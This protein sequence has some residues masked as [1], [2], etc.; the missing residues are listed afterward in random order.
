MTAGLVYAD[1]RTIQPRDIARARMGAVLAG[2]NPSAFA[3]DAQQVTSQEMASWLPWLRS[4]DGEI[5]N[6]RDRV[7]ARARDLIR[8]D[9]YAAG[10]INR[11]L[12]AAV[13]AQFHP[14]PKP[15]WRALQ[16]YCPALDST[17]AM[18]VAAAVRS[19]YQLWADDPAKHCDAERTQTVQQMLRLSFRHKMVDGDGMIVALWA[20]DHVGSGGARYATQLQVVDPDRLSNPFQKMDT[21]SQR[22]GVEIDDLGAPLGYHIR[23]AHQNDWYDAGQSMVWD[24]F[25]RETPWGRPIVVHD[26]DRERASQHRGNGLLTA[27]LSRFKMLTKFDSVTLQAAVLRT[28]VGFFV[29]SPYDAEQ[30]RMAMEAGDDSE[31]QLAPSYYQGLREEWHR[32]NGVT[33]GGVRMPVMA[34]GESIETISG[35]EHA[36]DFD[37]FQGA[38]LRSFAASTGQSVEEISVDFRKV[39]YSSFRGAMLQSWRTLIRRRKDFA[40]NTATPIYGAWLEE[41]LSTHLSGL[42]PRNAPPF[43][44]IRAAYIACEWIGPG[45]GWVDPVKEPQGEVLKLDAAMGTLAET[46]ANISGRYWLDILDERQVEEAAMRDRGLQLPN[47]AGGEPANQVASK[48]SAVESEDIMDRL[49]ETV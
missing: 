31:A 8:N 33:M 23:R 42:L 32:G 19:E 26:F 16:R 13:G 39:N 6:V 37:S 34:P 5:N 21:H 2:S 12:D 28:L 47:W 38:F 4:P 15:N 29:K 24:Y 43:M 45:R 40:M 1:G 11:L 35:G 7:V 44:D 30:I 3:Y 46:T 17:W 14:I 48:P 18:E 36:T 20:P 27:V 41:A 25:P 10:A 22:G 49:E 9:G